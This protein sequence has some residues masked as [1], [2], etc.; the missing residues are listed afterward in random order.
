MSD[1][2]T[3]I[4][5][6]CK[7]RG[8]NITEMCRASGAS[9]GS[10]TD[11]KMGRTSGLNTNTLLRIATHF[12]ITIESLLGTTP[13]QDFSGSI[14]NVTN[15]AVVAGNTASHINV[16]RTET[17]QEALSEQEQEVL[18][19]FHSLDMRKKTSV[20]SYLYELEDG[21]KKED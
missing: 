8:T 17:P 15:S 11:L 1:L 21:G 12:G 19:I 3:R 2:Y 18:R 13:A 6:L 5:G 20:L 14:S 7:E 9:R 10:L 4:E 16:N